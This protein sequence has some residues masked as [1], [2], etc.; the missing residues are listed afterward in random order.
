MSNRYSNVAAIAACGA[1][2]SACG[3][4]SGSGGY[5]APANPMPAASFS[6]PAQ[7]ASIHLG[8]SIAL[9]WTSTYATA[10]TASASSA[11]A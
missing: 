2:L 9:A 8:Q 6:T 1:L 10:C 4:G 11:T 5:M 3:G 7:A